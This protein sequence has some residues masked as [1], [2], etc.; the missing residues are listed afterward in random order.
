MHVAG[1]ETQLGQSVLDSTTLVV[2]RLL[3]SRVRS[4]VT[5]TQARQDL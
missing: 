5:M 1:V 3:W 4:I 2:G